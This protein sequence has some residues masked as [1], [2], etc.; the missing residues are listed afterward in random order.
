MREGLTDDAS[1][2]RLFIGVEA[3]AKVKDSIRKAEEELT[4]RGCRGRWV[5]RENIHLTLRYLGDCPAASV[6]SIET[7]LAA[8]AAKIRPFSVATDRFG[9]FPNARR[10]RVLWLGLE[11]T[12]DIQDLYLAVSEELASIGFAPE[13]RPFVPHITFGR[14]KIPAAVEL[15]VLG[16]IKTGHTIAIDEVTLFA[17]RL[18]P[19]GAKYE[20]LARVGFAQ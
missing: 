1:G 3:G 19:A 2:I 7:A 18:S 11:N 16:S 5:P 13:E 15:S 12:P 8:A 14:L 17:S 4:S 6:G 9:A 20:V 10:A